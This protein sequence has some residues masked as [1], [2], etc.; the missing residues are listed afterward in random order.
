MSTLASYFCRSTSSIF[1]AIGVLL[2][3]GM[4]TALSQVMQPDAGSAAVASA[5]VTPTR[6]RCE[7]RI[8]PLGVDSSHPRLDWI[9]SA[10][11]PAARGLSQTAYQILVASAP[12]LLAKDMG[13]L[14]DSSKTVSS[15]MSQIPYAGKALAAN[16]QCWW[17]VRVWDQSGG[18]S[19]WSPVAQWTMGVA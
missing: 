6:L 15:S 13:D 14:W 10:N 7:Y 17:K 4:L 12:D 19:A 9:L 16:Q 8:D 3:S 2:W 11:Q 18:F 1:L 5:S